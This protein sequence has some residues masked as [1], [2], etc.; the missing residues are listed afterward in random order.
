MAKILI[1][2]PCG[3]HPATKG[4]RQRVLSLADTLIS[5]G[6]EVHMALLPNQIFGKGSIT[7]MQA[8]WGERLHILQPFIG[9][10]LA[11]R[12][13][14]LTA[15]I[16]TPVFRA[17]LGLAN[18]KQ[19]IQNVDGIYTDWWDLQLLALQAQHHF[20]V[21]ICEYIFTSRALLNFP[22]TV[23]KVIDTHDIFSHRNESLLNARNINANWLTATP[24]EESEA[25]NRCDIVVGIQ[26]VESAELSRLTSSSVITV[27]HFIDFTAHD[28]KNLDQAD[29]RILFVGSDNLINMDG[30]CWFID[31]V[32]DL[33][34]ST[35]PDG[36]F[37]IVGEAGIALAS[38]YANHPHVE[39]VGTVESLDTEYA[40]ALVVINPV[41]CGTGLAIKS[42]EALAHGA[43]LLC[44]PS[45]ARGLQLDVDLAPPYAVAE[46]PADFAEKLT[47]M[48]TDPSLRERYSR[49]ASIFVKA[50]NRQQMAN[51]V[52]VI[53]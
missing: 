23:R 46:S 38:K 3:T 6:H 45:G 19:K 25:L 21:V 43:A 28:H 42:V 18:T 36:V 35:I 8:Y 10:T 9:W 39:I 5:A 40:E 48:L 13:R 12:S 30:C 17:M 31:E 34:T 44:T 16:M 53:E 11:F 1:V 50:W 29:K 37:R 49:S 4:N 7:E 32:L 33:V 20:S 41:Q 51:L 27:G 15:R 14:R 22:D 52:S 24:M 26:E 47:T 2:S